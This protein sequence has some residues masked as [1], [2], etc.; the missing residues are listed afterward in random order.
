M[1]NSEWKTRRYRSQLRCFTVFLYYILYFSYLKT[2]EVVRGA[3]L[4]FRGG[5]TSRRAF[6]PSLSVLVISIS[7]AKLGDFN[8]LRMLDCRAR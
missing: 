6:S 2:L 1:N 3:F 5:R 8:Y 7:N 4:V